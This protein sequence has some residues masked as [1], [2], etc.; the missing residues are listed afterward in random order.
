MLKV[1][2]LTKKF[3]GKTV[4]DSLSFQV[5]SGEVCVIIGPSGTGKSTLLR[6]LNLLETPEKGFL[7]LNGKEIDLAGTT[8]KERQFLRENI[9]MVFQTFNLYKNKTALQNITEPLIT[10]KKMKKEEANRIAE[11][12]LEKVGLGHRKNSYPATLSGG[13]QQRVGIARAMGMNSSIILFDEPTSALDP[14]LVS[15]VL[16]V[17]KKLV[18]ENITMLIVTHEMKF[19]KDIADQIIFMADGKMIESGPPE[20]I[21]HEPREERTKQFLKRFNE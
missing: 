15:E 20:V 13:E 6:C 8:R 18:S 4:F 12:L 9:S 19:A 21:F 2:D 14:S 11:E 5:N 1:R 3:N 10:V 7:T 16:A 17:M